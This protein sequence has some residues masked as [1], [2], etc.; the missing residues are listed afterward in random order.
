LNVELLAPPSELF[1]LGYA[2]ELYDALESAGLGKEMHVL[3]AGCGIGLASEPLHRSGRRITGVD[4]MVELLDFARERMPEGDFREADVHA[5]P[6][7]DETFD[8]AVSAQTFH[9]FQRPPAMLELIRVV[10]PGGLIAVWWKAL[11][12]DSPIRAFRERVARDC[13]FEPVPDLLGSGFRDFYSAGLAEPTLRII[14][15]KYSVSVE[16]FVASER[17][18]IAGPATDG[19]RGEQYLQKLYDRVRDR[20]AEGRQLII[21]A[22]HYLYFGKRPA[23]Q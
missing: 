18:R 17:I 14:P 1:R 13:D 4:R 22:I 12:F 16:A 8:A 20:L 6:F 7:E 3:D 2:P 11:A 23:G 5:L 19:A 9:L 15:W 10:R 21:P